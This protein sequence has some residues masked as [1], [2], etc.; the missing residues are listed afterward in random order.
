MAINALAQ[1]TGS[2]GTT[3]ANYQP[4][5]GNLV[6]MNLNSGG[7]P[8]ITGNRLRASAGSGGAVCLYAF[9]QRLVSA[10]DPVIAVARRFSGTGAFDLMTR[11]NKD[12]LGLAFYGY[13]VRWMEDGGTKKFMLIRWNAGSTTLGTYNDDWTAGQDRTIKIQATGSGATVTVKVFIDGVERIS[14]DDTD[15]SRIT[16]P[17][18]ACFDLLEL[19][20]VGATDGIHLDTFQIG[21]GSLEPLSGLQVEGNSQASGDYNT[22]VP[23]VVAGLNQVTD[24]GRVAVSG[25][26]VAQMITQF[27]TQITP[28]YHSNQPRFVVVLV[29]PGND[30][31]VNGTSAAD[32]YDLVCDYA[33]LV[34]GLGANARFVTAT[35]S[36]R[37]S[38]GL[39]GDYNTVMDTLNGLLR[40]DAAGK[41]DAL[42]DIAATTA[43]IGGGSPAAYTSD[44]V[45]YTQTT[46][47]A[48]RPEGIT[49]IN[50]QLSL[51]GG[52]GS[53]SGLSII[54][55]QLAPNGFLPRY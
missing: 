53:G 8:V 45:H 13:M 2:D 33:D 42:W 4:D 11:W 25:D 43:A 23:D 10:D 29:D 52:G 16:T 27:A 12:A 32:T 18:N 9:R 7:Q 50:S 17:G 40:T 3:I 46:A 15:G 38:G 20:T 26:T 6:G 44:G 55:L 19:G 36:H 24:Y 41:I 30:Y 1:F 47:D 14:Y 35:V 48:I 34:H 5:A 28:V 54:L 39:P 21:E 37:T 51:G 31:G 49:R 22:L